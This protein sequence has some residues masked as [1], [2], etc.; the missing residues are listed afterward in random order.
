MTSFLNDFEISRASYLNTLMV[1]D[2]NESHFCAETPQR[3]SRE[4]NRMN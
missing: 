4:S 1:H 2:Q 3:K